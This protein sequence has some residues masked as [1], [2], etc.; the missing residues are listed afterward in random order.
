MPPSPSGRGHNNGKKTSVVQFLFGGVDIFTYCNVGITW[1]SGAFKAGC[2]VEATNNSSVSLSGNQIQRDVTLSE[3][4]ACWSSNNNNNKH[5]RDGW[6][7][8]CRVKRKSVG[9]FTSM[10]KL[11]QQSTKVGLLT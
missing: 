5:G 10:S 11:Q 8:V 1:S 7:C 2:C 3:P 6:R 9:L 4:A